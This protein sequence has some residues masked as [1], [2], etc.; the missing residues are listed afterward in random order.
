MKKLLFVVLSLLF[1]SVSV[2][3]QRYAIIDTKYI[4]DK[5]PEYKEADS[6]LAQTSQHGKKR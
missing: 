6:K 3:A 5:M 4:L 2:L 1:T